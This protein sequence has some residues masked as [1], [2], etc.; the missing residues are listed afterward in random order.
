MRILMIAQFY[1]PIV[2]GEERIVQDLSRELT[3]RGHSVAVATLWHPGLPAYEEQDGVRVYRLRSSLRRLPQIFKE[4]ERQH[5]P[6]W[7]D[8]EVTLALHA[9][10]QQEQPEIVHAHNWMVHS[11]LPLKAAA[12]APLVMTLHDYSLVCPQKRLMRRNT[13][14]SGPALGKCLAC[15]ARHYGAFKGGPTALAQW[16]LSFVER[17]LVDLF[18]PISQSVAVRSGL[19][20]G[21][22]PYR[23]IPNFVPDGLSERRA[24]HPALEQLPAG[25]FFLFVG[26]LSGDKGLRVLLEAYAG[27]ADPWPLVLVGRRCGDTPAVFPA[28]VHH[29]GVLPHTA[30]MEAW[31]RSAVAVVPSTWEEPFGVVALEAMAAGRPVI[32]SAAGGLADVIVDGETGCLVPPADAAALGRAMQRLQADPLLRQRQGQAALRRL[33]QFQAAHVLPL[34]EQ[35]YAEL[36]RARR[37]AETEPS[38]LSAT[39]R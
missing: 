32:A 18:L 14:C 33:S 30:V 22:R 28:G 35:S 3:A 11:F 16:G 31:H 19:P 8:P 1:A 20:G 10:L 23:I 15:A 29:V 6:P 26:D 36:L 38:Q 4:T 7:P 9:V 13:P 17:R 39:V 12:G 34:V 37:G 5:A 21:D 25:E 27:L 2:G 24:P